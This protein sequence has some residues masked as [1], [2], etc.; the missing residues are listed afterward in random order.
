MF[1]KLHHWTSHL[2]FFQNRGA[3]LAT[4]PVEFW[5]FSDPPDSLFYICLW[6]YRSSH[7]QVMLRVHKHV[8]KTQADN[9]SVSNRIMGGL[10]VHLIS[11]LLCLIDQTLSET[12]PF[13]A[14]E[15]NFWPKA[16]H[17]SIKCAFRVR[18]FWLPFGSLWLPYTSLSLP[19]GFLWHVLNEPRI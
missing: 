11:F 7:K 8:T 9:T 12:F 15:C 13:V 10:F 16:I 6:S 4:I 17:R 1:P 19:V 5:W 18:S 2:T 3:F 14:T